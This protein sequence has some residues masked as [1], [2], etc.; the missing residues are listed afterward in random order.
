MSETASTLDA[1]E[2][3][4]FALVSLT[5]RA[6]AEGGG[7]QLTFQQ[8]RTLVVLGNAPAAM[9]ISEI[10]RRIAA[11]G[12]STSRLIRRLQDHGLVQTAQDRVDGRVVRVRMTSAGTAVRA[13]V[14]Q[15]RRQLIAELLGDAAAAP[16][17]GDV[18]RLVAALEPAI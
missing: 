9:K 4:A 18:A 6:L 15:R 14:V 3:L 13:G 12:P 17:P 1:T 10:A 7:S 5:A 16:A 8:W 11:S 2:T